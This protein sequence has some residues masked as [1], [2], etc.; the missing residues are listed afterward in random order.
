MI[1]L[2]DPKKFE[3]DEYYLKRAKAAGLHQNYTIPEQFHVVDQDC[4]KSKSLFEKP[5]LEPMS[6]LHELEDQYSHHQNENGD[7]HQ[8]L[9]DDDEEE[10]EGDEEGEGEGVWGENVEEFKANF[11]EHYKREPNEKEIKQFEED[12]K[13]SQEHED[14]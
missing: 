1:L 12:L 5:G 6:A 14:L 10:N 11:K 8:V 13:D 7:D 4:D 3:D 9:E 2:R